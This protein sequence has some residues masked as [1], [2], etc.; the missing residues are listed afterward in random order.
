[1]DSPVRLAMRA[2]ANGLVCPVVIESVVW[3]VAAP[4]F[5]LLASCSYDNARVY[6]V[7]ES[8]THTHTHIHT[9]TYTHTCTHTQ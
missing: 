5:P 3:V 9:H 8:H 7:V 1:M 4:F 2:L 6:I